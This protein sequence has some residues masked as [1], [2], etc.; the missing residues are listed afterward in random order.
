MAAENEGEVGTVRPEL[1]FGPRGAIPPPNLVPPVS[2]DPRSA[3][4]SAWTP[5]MPLRRCARTRESIT[6]FEFWTRGGPAHR[7][8][9]VALSEEGLAA[10]VR[11]AEKTAARAGLPA[12]EAGEAAAARF[13]RTSYLN[14]G[15]YCRLPCRG[16]GLGVGVAAKMHAA[17]ARRLLASHLEQVSPP[18]TVSGGE[19][20]AAVHEFGLPIRQLGL[21][22]ASVSTRHVKE[23]VVTEMVARAMREVCH[24]RLRRT[25]YNDV[26][27]AKK[28]LVQ[29][30]N[31]LLTRTSMKEEEW[32]AQWRKLREDVKQV[33]SS[34]FD[35][36]VSEALW[37]RVHGALLLQRLAELLG[38]VLA[39]RPEAYRLDVRAPFSVADVVD[40][41]PRVTGGGV[42][43]RL[44]ERRRRRSA[45][46]TL[47]P[48]EEE[49]EEGGPKIDPFKTLGVATIG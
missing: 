33:L 1:L 23:S 25:E 6:T 35:V 31:A 14:D 42:G 26:P 12:A 48:I 5:P 15:A 21:L 34:K 45:G 10:V 49:E 20:A 32:D 37:G 28:M 41:M 7:G 8:V 4:A 47:P 9:P 27:F 29:C 38:L 43:L 44:A 39:E 3:S 11:E 40:V 22:S 16:P 18:L 13:E 46:G 24:T 36:E 17:A 19:L 2:F 30:L